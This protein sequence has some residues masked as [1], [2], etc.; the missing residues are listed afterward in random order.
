MTT[1]TNFKTPYDAGYNAGVYGAN[2][3]NSHFK[4]FQ[5]KEKM[6][7]WQRGNDAGSAQR[8][9]DSHEERQERLKRFKS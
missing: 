3:F 7:E 1:E 8:E 9:A 4:W 6:Q 2:N 5:T